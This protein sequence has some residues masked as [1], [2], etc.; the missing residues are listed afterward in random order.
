M[1]A[2]AMVTSRVRLGAI[3][4]PLARRRPWKVARE[5]VTLDHLSK[6]RPALPV[7]LGALDDAGFGRVAEPTDR[8]TRAECLDEAL[9]ILTGL[10]SGKPIEADWSG[11]N[12][13]S[14]RRRIEAGP[15]FVARRRA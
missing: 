8:R 2:F 3:I 4:M 7:G 12:V 1:A 11:A 14:L 13:S 9:N 6:G 15:P 5:A 10:W